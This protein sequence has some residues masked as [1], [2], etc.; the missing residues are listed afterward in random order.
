[1]SPTA[2]GA[3]R[4]QCAPFFFL[5]QPALTRNSEVRQP[6]IG[7]ADRTYQRIDDLA[8]DAVGERLSPSNV[9]SRAR[10]DISCPAI[11]CDHGKG[12]LWRRLRF[13]SAPGVACAFTSAIPAVAKG[14]KRRSRRQLAPET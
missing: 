3:L 1:V 2:S 14:S 4:S 11:G 13:R 9:R 12:A 7:G 8:L 6:R 10:I 5:N